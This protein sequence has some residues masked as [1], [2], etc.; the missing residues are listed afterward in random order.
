LPEPLA[1][2]LVISKDESLISSDWSS[3]R[4]SELVS[5]EWRN[6]RGIEKVPSIQGAVSQEFK[7]GAV[8]LVGAGS[9]HN[10]D[11]RPSPFSIFG[12]VAVRV[13][14]PWPC[15]RMEVKLTVAAFNA[16]SRSKLRPLVRRLR[17]RDDR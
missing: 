8:E 17:E 2:P 13:P 14:A 11:L 3:Q 1:E 4:A 7:Q 9:R 15:L 10:T 12:A 5:L 16:I 6:T